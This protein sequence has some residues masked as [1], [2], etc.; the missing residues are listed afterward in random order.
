VPQ[1][2]GGEEEGEE[3]QPKYDQTAEGIS[4]DLVKAMEGDLLSWHEKTDDNYQHRREQRRYDP[5]SG[6][7]RPIEWLARSAHS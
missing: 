7:K 6:E 4:K 2:V 3:G 1:T 5:T